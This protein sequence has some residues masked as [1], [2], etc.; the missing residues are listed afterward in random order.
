MRTILTKDEIE[1][2]RGLTERPLALIS[3]R[4]TYSIKESQT[5]IDYFEAFF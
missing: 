5:V 2:A 3:H 1:L 4:A